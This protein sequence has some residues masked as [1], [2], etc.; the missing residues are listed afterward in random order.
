[1]EGVRNP[2]LL[3]PWSWPRVWLEKQQQNR[4]SMGMYTARWAQ[5]HPEI[6]PGPGMG[7]CCHPLLPTYQ[8]PCLAQGEAEPSQP[9]WLPQPPRL[10]ATSLQLS[11]YRD[12]DFEQYLEWRGSR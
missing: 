12:R 5:L 9:P 11:C 3:P 1:M 10:C 7:S 4:V 6:L 8:Q 2:Q